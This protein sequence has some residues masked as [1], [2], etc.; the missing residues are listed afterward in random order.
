MEDQEWMLLELHSLEYLT[1]LWYFSFIVILNLSLLC[2]VYLLQ[3]FVFYVISSKSMNKMKL[4]SSKMFGHMM[5]TGVWVISL[6]AKSIEGGNSSYLVCGM[7][8]PPRH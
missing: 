6:P 7:V 2:N 4:I 5:S 8:I 1:R 3:T